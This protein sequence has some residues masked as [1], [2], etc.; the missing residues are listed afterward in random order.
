MILIG[1]TNQTLADQLTTGLREHGV[2]CEWAE[3]S[4]DDFYQKLYDAR[5]RAVVVDEAIT[6]HPAEMVLDMIL[7]LTKRV[8]VFLL[9]SG[10][11]FGN[12]QRP[13]V[14]EQLKIMNPAEP[15]RIVAAL[16]ELEDLG[17]TSFKS[18]CSSVPFFNIKI[19]ARKLTDH[20]GLGILTIDASDFS[21]IGIEYGVEVYAVVKDVF[22]DILYELWGRKGCFRESDILCRHSYSSNVYY[23]FLARSRETG[24]LPYPGALEKV[25]DRLM[26]NIQK[27]LWEEVCT[28]GPKRRIPDC[29]KSIP[30][31]GV[32]YV[33]VLDN[34]CIDPYEIIENGIE[35][36]KRTIPFQ[37]RRLRERQ[38]ELMQ[39][40]IQSTGYLRPNYQAIFHLQGIEKAALEESLKTGRLAPIQDHIFGFESLIRI[41]PDLVEELMQDENLKITGIKTKFLRPDILFDLAKSTKVS[42]ELDQACLRHAARFSLDLPGVLMVNILPRNLYY[43]DQLTPMFEGRKAILFEVSESEA[44]SNFELM[45]QCIELLEEMGLGIAA[46][47]FGKGFSSLER[48]IKLQPSVIKF[49]RSMIEGIDKDPIR[50][51]YVKG[52]VE[53]AKI[54]KTTVLAEGVETWEEAALLK[55]MGIELIQGFLLHRPQS[56]EVILAGLDGEVSTD[57]DEDTLNIDTVA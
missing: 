50:K 6:N 2:A 21:K 42:L 49:D 5:Y 31:P 30:M 53:A 23:V 19:P 55:D 54:I 35:D 41:N 56:A 16:Q 39:S 52:M 7:G 40:L 17:R 33:G 24:A 32:G 11:S 29:V 20:G 48:I 15:E 45:H 3:P 47:D 36:S 37:S 34:P 26:S 28:Y 10:Q 8:P 18:N 38:L 43:V 51:A 44:I 9:G 25:A 1:T 13:F 14:G 57:D 12:Y 22:Q 46:D 4:Q 27:E